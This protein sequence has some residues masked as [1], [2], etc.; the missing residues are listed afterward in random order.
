MKQHLIESFE[1]FFQ[2]TDGMSFF[3]PG[4]V[5][6]IGEHIDYNGGFVFPCA[7]SY[8][9]YAIAALRTDR[10]IRVYSEPFSKAPYMF[11]LDNIKKD[12]H[13]AWA[14]YIKGS[15]QALLDHG[16]N[17]SYGVDI[18]MTGT[19]P[20]SAGLS[21]SASLEML[22]IFMLNHFFSLSI[23]I[24]DMAKLGKYAEN[25]F[26]GVNSGIMDQFAVI[27]GKKD[28]AILLNTE[29]LD[30]KYVPLKL[31]EESLLIINTN[32]KRGLADS[33]YNERFSE[34]QQALNIAKNHY[35]IENLCQLTLDELSH[36]EPRMSPLLFKRS[37]HIVTEQWRTIASK[38]ALVKGDI[39]SF[40]KLM[41][42]SHLSLKDDYEV[43]CKELDLLQQAL[44]DEGA[45]GARMTGA[46]FGGCVV[47]I[48]PTIKKDII[49]Q[50][51]EKIYKSNIGYAPTFYEV[52]PSDG[53][54]LISPIK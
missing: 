46:G 51:V 22:I 8:G 26:V 21:S 28:H 30:F 18:Y 7:L 44:L 36:L 37:R 48:V 50:H 34:S 6:L 47:A 54:K 4:R 3:S 15:I 12:D 49:K 17:I 19:M 1:Q 9:T 25:H 10:M 11:S 13:E 38:E 33:K 53:T 27:A 23:G 2:R 16:Y 42:E 5:N 31:N 41:T 39:S 40:S 43:T 35:K 32:K 24:K 52:E 29:S 20:V 45:L 14:N